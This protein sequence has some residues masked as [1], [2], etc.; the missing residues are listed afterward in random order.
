MAPSKPRKPYLILSLDGGGIRGVL[1]AGILECLESD[2]P[3][4]SEVQLIAGTSTGG[5][6]GLALA[7]GMSPE[8]VKALYIRCGEKIF[9]K[10]PLD[11]F[12]DQLLHLDVTI[13]RAKYAN[14]ALREE[15]TNALSKRAPTLADLQKHVLISTFNLEDPDK[16]VWKAKYFNNYPGDKDCSED[17][18]AVALRTS[19]APTYF[20]SVGTYIDGGVVSNNP[21]VCAVTQALHS[22]VIDPPTEGEHEEHL[23]LDDIYLISVGT[24]NN[25]KK[26]AGADLNWGFGKW[27]KPL[28][29]VLM[30]GSVDVADYQVRNLLGE[31]Y[32]RI[33]FPFPNNEAIDMDD[34][35][36]IGELEAWAPQTQ[37]QD[38]LHVLDHYYE[39]LASGHVHHHA[40]ANQA[41]R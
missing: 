15:L 12:F 6:L 7:S 26:I 19:A 34:V 14:T 40:A 22:V 38:A 28:Y 36:R 39:H 21:S 33:N 29:D 41:N 17:P 8:E 10:R 3:F 11:K 20:P 23:T 31:H 13:F 27:W 9:K 35:S 4:L 30:D 18:I 2:R 16:K 5:I 32:A 1:T 25:P 24:G 37:L